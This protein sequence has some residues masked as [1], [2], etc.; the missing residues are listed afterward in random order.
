MEEDSSYIFKMDRYKGDPFK[1]QR[2]D[3]DRQA[4]AN[5]IDVDGMYKEFD[6]ILDTYNQAEKNVRAQH[7][8]VWNMVHPLMP[9]CLGSLHPL[10]AEE[11]NK[12]Q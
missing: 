2:E 7:G 6:K 5:G 10:I 11:L 1:K 9:P 4:R 12:L 3:L 8:W